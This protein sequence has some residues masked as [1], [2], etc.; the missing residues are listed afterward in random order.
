MNYYMRPEYETIRTMDVML[1]YI[2]ERCH[3]EDAFC[4]R[5]GDGFA[6]V[7]RPKF[8]EDCLKAAAYFKDL[9]V[10]RVAILGE[11][12][13]IYVVATFGLACA[14]KV[15]VLMD[16]GAAPEEFVQMLQTTR[17]PMMLYTDLYGKAGE[18]FGASGMCR[19]L[20]FNDFYATISELEPCEDLK[21]N[22]PDDVA[23]IFF[24]SSTTGN[25]KAVPLTHGNISAD[26]FNASKRIAGG[27][28]II[29]ALPYFHCFGYIVSLLIPLVNGCTVFINDTLTNLPRDFKYCQTMLMPA[30]PG[31][32]EMLAKVTRG[33]K[34]PEALKA[35]LGPNFKMF[36]SGGGALNKDVRRLY[37]SI[38]VEMWEGYGITECASVVTFNNEP[39][40]YGYSLATA[41]DGCEIKIA[42]DGEI[43]VRGDNVATCY[44]NAPEETAKAFTDGWFHTGDLGEIDEKGQL[45]IIGRI[46]KLIILSNGE[47]IPAEPLEELVYQL[48]YV[49]DALVHEVDGAIAAEVYFYK[50]AGDQTEQFKQDMETINQSLPV[51]RRMTKLIVR[52]EEFAK[53]SSGK[54]KIR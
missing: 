31:I 12:N 28:K 41:I 43:L 50:E 10:E 51:N 8:R 7:S 5:E 49:Q 37:E 46:K 45:H 53:T 27:G 15:A 33:K 52:Q 20:S 13:Y 29:S 34:N 30:V 4:Y 11:N 24:T 47:N 14:G 26:L 6:T 39:A 40:T 54:I 23:M 1:D 3:E 32:I 9:P 22:D 21:P 42:E 18:K 36:I 44:D 17:C 19:T 35:L 25:R 2:N 38:G 48:P 16:R